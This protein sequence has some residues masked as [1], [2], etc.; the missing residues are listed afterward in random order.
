MTASCDIVIDK[1]G[2]WYY[3]GAHMFR[4]DILSIFFEHLR[5]DDC[6]KYYIALGD[7]ISYL[8]VEDTAFV[9]CTVFRN[10]VGAGQDELSIALT[11]DSIERLEMESLEVGADNILYCRVKDGRFLARFSRKSYY[12]LAEY[13]EEHEG[14]FFISLNNNRYFIRYGC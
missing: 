7:E 13:I 3:R 5:I 9:V 1:E 2:V 11:D 6:G 12:Q 10:C 14:K 8:E 4:K